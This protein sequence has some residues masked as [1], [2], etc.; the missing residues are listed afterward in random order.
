MM[1]NGS[2]PVAP[3]DFEV[4]YYAPA[5]VGA[6]AKRCGRRRRRSQLLTPSSGSGVSSSLDLSLARRLPKRCHATVQV[7][8]LHCKMLA[9]LILRR[10]LG[11]IVAI[12]IE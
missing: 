6:D 11:L 5:V 8:R 2:K 4:T 1:M 9:I 10:T 12:D 3:L 7:V